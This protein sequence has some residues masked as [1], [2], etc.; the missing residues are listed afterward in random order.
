M[1]FGIEKELA[2]FLQAVLAGNLLYLVYTVL[3]VW[4]R[5][6]KHNLFWISAE[7]LIYWIGTGFY[8]FVKIYETCNGT[9]RWYFVVGV[10]AGAII[11]HYTIKKISKTYCEKVKKRVI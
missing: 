3:R 8:L 2:V 10:L 6:I 11:T 1:V 5:I 7:D 4:R 9:I